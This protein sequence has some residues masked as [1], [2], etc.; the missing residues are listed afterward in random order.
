M[1][2]TLIDPCGPYTDPKGDNNREFFKCVTEHSNGQRTRDAILTVSEI[3]ELGEKVLDAL[4]H[5]ADFR[6]RYYNLSRTWHNTY[7]QSGATRKGGDFGDELCRLFEQ[8][9]PPALLQLHDIANIHRYVFMI[10]RRSLLAMT[11][12]DIDPDAAKDD[13]R[14]YHFPPNDASVASMRNKDLGFNEAIP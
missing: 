2:K 11:G 6:L 1:G 10:L 9:H 5:D 4:A 14:S 7:Y 12:H 13:T 8:L 3:R